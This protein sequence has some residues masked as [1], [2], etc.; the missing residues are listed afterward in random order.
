M[1]SK[2]T[3]RGDASD[4]DYVATAGA[5]EAPVY[6]SS[7][8]AENTYR[9]YQWYLD[10]YLTV[11]GDESGA[12]VDKISIE[13]SGS[14]VKVGIID[15]GFDISNLDLVGRFDIK[16]SFDPR[17]T[18]GVT[19]IAPDSAA[20]AHGTWVSGVIGASATNQLGAVGVAPEATLVGYYAR[21][22]FGGSSVDELA[23]LLA[24]QVN[25]DVS[26][27]SWGFS[28]AFSDNFKNPAWDG[29]EN[30]LANAVENG[31]GSLG[32]I[33]VF[34]AGND[35]QNISHT[36]ADGDN[37]NNHSM[38]NSRLVITTAASTEDGHIAN[39]STPGASILVTAPGDSI[40]T[41]ALNNGDGDATN[42]FTFVS[43]TSFAAPVVSGIVAL[44]LE[45]NPDLGYRDVQDIL[46][47]SSHKLDPASAGWTTNGATNWNG[48]G[49]IVSHDYGFG[50]VDAH[51]AVRLAQTWTE[52]STAANE[53][54]INVTGNVGSN[55]L[56]AQSGSNSFVSTVTGNYEH[57]SIDWV[58]IDVT[59]KNARNGDLKI[60]LISPD[61]T[62]SVLLDHPGG[63][64][65]ASGNLNFTFS[66][67]HNWGETPNGNWT[68]VIH[69]TGT[70]GTDSIVSYALRIYGND[71]G[72]DDTYFYTDD[73]A[74]AAG[75]RSVLSDGSGND[76]INAAAT[77]TDL[78][79]DLNP[80]HSSTIA[81]RPIEISAGTVIE[82]VFGG[83]G[84]D[85]IIGNDADN[86][87][88]GGHGHNMLQGGA[89]N[90]TLDG[91]P[92]GSILVGGIGNDSYAIR[93]AGDVVVENANEGTDTGL[94]YM[95]SYVLGANIEN[96]SAELTSGQTLTGNDGDNWL[97]GNV[98]NDT[99]VGGAGNDT[100]IGGGGN[101]G[102]F[103]GT[104]ND[105]YV[106]D[107]LGDA[108]VEYPGEGIDAAFVLVSG[109][110]L[111][112]NVETGVIGI[113]T[114][115]TLTGND[116][117]NVLIGGHG[118]DTLIGGA[119]DD[120]ICG[121]AGADAMIGGMGDDQYV[122]DNL[123]DTIVEHPGAGT[124][125]AY[126]GMTGYVLSDNVEIGVVTGTAGAMLIAG[127]CDTVLWG[128]SGDDTL[129]G[130]EGND[131]IFGGAG[132]DMMLGGAGSD[133]YFVDNL[134][135]NIIEHPGEGIDTAYVDVSGYTLADN[136]ELGA[137]ATIAG[138]TLSGN[139]G[140]NWLWGNAGN[141][142]LH[143][144]AGNDFLSGGAGAD[145]LAGG[146]GND[147]YIVDNQNE[148][149][150]ENANEGY[151][152]VFSSAA[153]YTI[154]ANVEAGA[155]LS[156]D[157]ATLR[158]NDQGN[159]LWG[160]Q[161]NDTLI[162]G[163]GNDTLV[164]GGGHDILTGGGGSDTFVFK[165]GE[166]AGDTVTDFSGTDHGDLLA[167]SGYGSAEDGAKFTQI[168][169][170][171]WE[172]SSADG[173]VHEQITFAAHAAITANDWHF[174]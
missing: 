5:V 1:P 106:V 22:G 68:V 113:D 30:A 83:D 87:L 67:N 108:I 130:R 153:D 126:V 57:F 47:L 34:A 58:E 37:T 163:A 128:S 48:G 143:G 101:D 64:T 145:T 43:G 78:V 164:G 20:E 155:A 117:S 121:N 136:V 139:A 124:D 39:F 38:T 168:D 132:A 72:A 55:T 120:Y 172:V 9:S 6:A 156:D 26:N 69:D 111:A 134:S 89:G 147:V 16:N 46:A 141:D 3:L 18:T 160:R 45:A 75:D 102:L 123:G 17:D 142:T 41:T 174:V 129:I 24:L 122:V 109:Y 171:H 61:G 105:Q 86:R 32:T 119:G 107:S 133:T 80:G 88:A 97:R 95:S 77:T 81:G 99:L 31:R 165:R 85:L 104:G 158:A 70:S 94:V 170:T 76:T 138:M 28:N 154:A 152:T 53:Q 125:Y 149:V 11:G 7:L 2:N 96:A 103:G 79:L 14:G 169:D 42:D 98:G 36:T 173:S 25:V 150:F 146:A 12:N 131:I 33:Y 62:D 162:G 157:G 137:V 144:G 112:G 116:E 10:G 60:E 140:D 159:S 4:G 115:A 161:G 65:N 110:T 56:L 93:S 151:D 54:V 91:G 23:H 92:D 50:L 66:T 114:G 118:N 82:N 100:L 29:V 71:H 49:N 35:R 166:A 8:A 135:D 84:N 21:F 127:H 15:Q 74:A 40:L 52:H 90:D 44:M 13:Y 19:S 63:G 27:N 73:F 59:L 167:F 148:V 51:A